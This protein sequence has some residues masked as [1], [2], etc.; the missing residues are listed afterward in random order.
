MKYPTPIVPDKTILILS[1]ITEV[2]ISLYN[3]EIIYLEM[4]LIIFEN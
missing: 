1:S 3:K 2:N 4:M